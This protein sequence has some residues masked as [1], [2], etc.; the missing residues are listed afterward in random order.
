M[1]EMASFHAIKFF[2]VNE[3]RIDGSR[4]K[5][6]TDLQSDLNIY[7]DDAAELIILLRDRFKVDISSFEI[8]QYFKGE[9]FSFMEFLGLRPKTVYRKLLIKDLVRAVEVGYLV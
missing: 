9:G 7:G 2:V 3:F 6:E 4:I 8:D 5:Y 1:T